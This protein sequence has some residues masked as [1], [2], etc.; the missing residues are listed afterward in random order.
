MD[1]DQILPKLF[2]GSCPANEEDIDRLKEESGI[3]AVLNLQTDDDFHGWNINWPNLE[4]H[5]QRS[6]I[7]VCRVP[8]RDF[9]PE[10]LRTLLPDCVEALGDL[11]RD[12]HSVYVH[13]N[14]G[15]NRSPSTVIAYL[16]WVEKWDLE[17]A[18]DHV[19]ECRLCDP[20]MDV[21]RLATEDRKGR[22]DDG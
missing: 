21:I 3:T 15:V 17:K 22:G 16:H 7:E 6:G 12:G 13:C 2:V 11:L 10:S 14:A 9:S 19:M 20:Y 5:Y 8:V 4:S 18:M 1:V